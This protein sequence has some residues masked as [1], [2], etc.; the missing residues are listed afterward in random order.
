MA[1][2]LKHSQLGNVIGLDCKTTIAYRGV[3]DAELQ[4]GFP[5]PS[6]FTNRA[7]ST[8]DATSYGSQCAQ[9][10]ASCD[11]EFSF[12]QH[13]LPREEFKS[14]LT[15]C[16]NLNIVTPKEKP[17]LLP[18]FV[19]LFLHGGGFSLGGNAWPQ[20]DPSRLVELSIEEGSPIIG[21]NINYRIQDH[22]EGFGGDPN[23]LTVVG[24]SAGS[25][26]CF[27]H[28]ESEKP[29]L[30]RMVAMGG[31][32]L[33][34][35]QI[36]ITLA[37]GIYDMVMENLGLSK[38]ATADQKIN[39]LKEAS[40]DTLVAAA[41]KL[42]MLPIIDGEIV[43]SPATFSEWSFQDT[44]LLSAK[45][46]ESIVIGDC[47]MDS[48]I[49]FYMIH[50]RQAEMEASFIKSASRSL[51]NTMIKDD[52]LSKCNIGSQVSKSQDDAVD[53]ILRFA[54]DIGFYA[55]LTTIASGFPGKARILEEEVQ[56]LSWQ[57]HP[58]SRNCRL[59]GTRS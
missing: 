32:P 26:S 44:T 3:K 31:I 33:L 46:C 52:L 14:S 15:D 10:P 2:E 38:G 4:H 34:L 21:I 6:L 40:I 57:R 53:N 51:K 25:I 8:I 36:P 19:F 48:S 50:D 49:L 37:S 17:Q 11:F 23:N 24:E 39:A 35:K 54:H 55:P 20:Y 1:V 27:L 41:G 12:I 22:I 5:E 58:I 9:H 29:L 16:L 28:L 42:P 18:V 13:E 47:E 45:W 56:S 59:C 43:K 7:G 30:N